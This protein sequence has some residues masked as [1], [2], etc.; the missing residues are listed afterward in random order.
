MC[1]ALD[2]SMGF[3][4]A[5]RDLDKFAGLEKTFSEVFMPIIAL[6]KVA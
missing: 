1:I 5:A 2:Y 4:A 3:R 6:Q